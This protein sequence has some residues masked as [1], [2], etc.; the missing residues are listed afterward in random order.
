M[1]EQVAFIL[2]GLQGSVDIV[3]ITI[4]P[5]TVVCY[6]LATAGHGLLLAWRGG[7]VV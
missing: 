5:Q 7:R 4:D 3:L 1:R 2:H 6:D